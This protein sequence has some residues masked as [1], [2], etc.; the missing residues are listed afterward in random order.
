MAAGKH[1]RFEY[2]L[3]QHL[4]MNLV[5]MAKKRPTTVATYIHAAPVEG[6]P[7]LKKLRKLLRNVAPS[8]TELIKWNI[9]F[10]VEPRFLF[11]FSAHKAHLGFTALQD[12]FEPFRKE[13]AD[14][15]TTKMGIL[16]IRYVDPLP[17]DLIR[18]IA[19]YRLKIV[20]ERDDD[21]FW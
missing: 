10:Y 12:G 13:L 1:K 5:F 11:S 7:H 4:A 19:K 9:P 8:A 18:K 6:Q 3:T 14:Y 20:S 21:S 2:A 15:E 16:K 17:E